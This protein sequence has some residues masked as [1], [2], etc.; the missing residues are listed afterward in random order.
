MFRAQYRQFGSRQTI[1]LNH[2]VDATGT[3]LA[4]VRWYELRKT[5]AGPWKI[6]QQGT[7]SPNNLHRWMG[8]IAMD[9]A[10]NIA[11]GYSVASSSTFPGLRVATRKRTTAKGKLGPEVLIV[12]GGGSQT[13]P[14]ARWGDYGS[15]DVDPARACTFWYTSMYYANT[16][17]A[18][19]RTRIAEIRVPGC[20]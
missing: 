20:H 1:L 14:A 18:G 13:H 9:Q 19:W 4:G 17:A 2:T 16:S 11:L 8:S 12:N 5:G 10:G 15:M 3:E 7:Y 6:F